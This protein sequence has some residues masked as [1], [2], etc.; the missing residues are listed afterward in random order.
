M[1]TTYFNNATEQGPQFEVVQSDYMPMT[2]QAIQ[3]CYKCGYPYHLA[4]H[5]TLGRKPSQ[6]GAQIPFNQ[7]PK[8]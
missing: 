6:R 8:N 2:Q 4:T 7:A 3:T 5:C 1:P